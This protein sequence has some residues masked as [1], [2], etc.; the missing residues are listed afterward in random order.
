MTATIGA[1]L[2]MQGISFYVGIEVNRD[3]IEEA[4]GNAGE[5]E[6]DKSIIGLLL[7][8]IAFAALGTYVQ[9][10]YFLPAGADKAADDYSNQ[11]Y[12]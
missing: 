3:A 7:G 1:C 6:F 8:A 11:Q 10:K 5:G 9:L 4:A 2:L 12:A